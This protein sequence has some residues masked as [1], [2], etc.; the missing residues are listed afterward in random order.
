MSTAP[1]AEGGHRSGC[2]YN[3]HFDVKTYLNNY[4]VL[5]NNP[6]LYRFLQM[7]HQLVAAGSIPDGGRLLDVGSGPCIHSVISTGSRC[8]EI[9]CSDFVEQNRDEILRWVNGAIDAHNWEPVFQYVCKLEGKSDEWKTR[10][11]HIRQAIK[12]VVPC[13]V[14]QDNP[15]A[16]LVF[17]PFDVITSSLCLEAA[18][19]DEPSY[20]KAVKRLASLLK[21]GG[22]LIIGGVHGQSFYSVA[23]ETFSSLPTSKQMIES[24]FADAGLGDFRWFVDDIEKGEYDKAIGDV[25]D[26]P[27]DCTGIF[28]VS[29]TKK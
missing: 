9:V 17:E 7:M 16:P 23:K 27:A 14:H 25:F 3:T 20:R 5:E 10:Q 15:L 21:P 22:L 26:A 6:Y 2:D 29:A 8:S 13:D 28:A 19:L 24:V 11:S 1:E 4:Y 18:C 12:H